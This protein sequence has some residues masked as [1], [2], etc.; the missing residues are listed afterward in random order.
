MADD[1]SN[2]L[3]AGQE[4]ARGL[5]ADERKGAAYNALKNTY[6]V[7]LAGDPDT[8][9]K[10]QEYMQKEQTNPIAVKQAQATLTGTDLENTGKAQT[11]D[12]NALANPERLTGIKDTNAQTEATTAQTLQNTDQSAQKFPGELEQQKATLA[13]TKAQTGLAGAETAHANA[14]TAQTKLAMNTAEGA[15]LRS[16]GMGVLAAL[17]DVATNGGDVGGKFDELAPIIAKMEGVSP[18][19]L[20]GLRAAL[21][22]DPQGTINS[23]SSAI[24]AANMT[25]M[26][27]KSATGMLAMQKFSQGQMTLADGLNFTRQRVAAVP[28]MVQQALDL[29]PQ[30]SSIPTVAKAKA[31]VPGTPEYQFNALIHSIQGNLSLDDLRSLREGGLSLGRA[32]MAEFAASANAIANTDL[33]LNKGMLKGNLQRVQNTYRG[34]TAAL[35]AQIARVRKTAGGAGAA[36]PVK[37]F[38]NGTVYTDSQGNKATTADGGKTWTP[39]K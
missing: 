32:N 31:L 2:A 34:T 36:A 14:E 3:A 22:K 37:Q 24:Q 21:V 7:A 26:G 10:D 1:T 13:G 18:D 20:Q 9:I 35:D 19:H 6:G 38:V 5:T 4:F 33:G 17:S 23:L 30:M 8:A 28:D 39:V 25:A 29:M 27:G 12:Y 15:Q 11:N 16:T